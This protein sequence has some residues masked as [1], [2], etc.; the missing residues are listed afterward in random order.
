M[1]GPATGTIIPAHWLRGGGTWNLIF[2]FLVPVVTVCTTG[3]VAGPQ[4]SKYKGI[5]SSLVY[6][7]CLENEY[8]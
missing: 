1:P 6:G 4:T 3:A 5:W 2:L 8:F 7:A